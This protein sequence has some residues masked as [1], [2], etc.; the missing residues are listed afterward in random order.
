VALPAEFLARALGRLLGQTLRLGSAITESYFVA[1]SSL[2]EARGLSPYRFG[3]TPTELQLSAVLLLA[4]APKLPKG[5]PKAA[6][7][8][9]AAK[10]LLDRSQIASAKIENEWAR[11]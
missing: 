9:L 11:F 1:H 2:V 10:A 7:L 8:L 3:L 6:R 4:S 5:D